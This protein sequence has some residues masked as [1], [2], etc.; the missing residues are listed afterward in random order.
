MIF[1]FQQQQN[2]SSSKT[3]KHEEGKTP[4]ATEL[5][6]CTISLSH[7]GKH[8]T[9]H[10]FSLLYQLFIK[11][12]RLDHAQLLAWPVGVEVDCL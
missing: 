3:L 11:F 7:L 9:S 12:L 4:Y 1:C 8:L 6:K 10:F 5:Q 2:T